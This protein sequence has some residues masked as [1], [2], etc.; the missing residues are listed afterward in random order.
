[1]PGS[2]AGMARGG[3]NSEL[4]ARLA[5]LAK[6]AVRS[7]PPAKQAAILDAAPS[8][9]GSLLRD[10]NR[11]LV[12][13]R[14][15]HGAVAGVDALRDA[16]A[17][18]LHVSVRYQTV[19]VAV[20][21]SDL[22][23]V[24]AVPRV[25]GVTENLAPIVSAACPAGDVVSEGDLQ[26]K[27]ADARSTYGV[28]GSGVT[29][30][31]LSD[32]FA[33][34]TTP[35]SIADNVASGD[36]PGAANPCGHTTPVDTTGDTYGGSDA[37]DEGRAMAQVVHDLAPGAE[38]AFA[39]AFVSVSSFADNIRAL[40][41]AG[42]QVIV[43]DIIYLD[44]PFFQEGPVAVAVNDAT[45]DGAAYFSAAG[46]NNL[47]VGGNNISSWETPQFRGG[48]SNICPPSLVAT[49]SFVSDCLDFDPSHGTDGDFS[50]VVSNGA[51][52]T[53]DLQWAQPWNG[54]TSD[55][56][57]YLLDS[58]GSVVAASASDN[59]GLT[60][61]P[62]EIFSWDNTSGTS[63]TVSLAID[64]CFGICN[65]NADVS[66]PRVKFALLQNG[67]GVTSTEYP[68]SLGGDIVGPT[69]FG[70]SGAPNAM[71]VGAIR[72]NTS[73]APESFSSRGPVVHYFGA[74]SGTTPAPPLSA[75]QVISKPDLVATDCNVT[76]GFFGDFPPFRFCG[77]SAAAPHAA[78]IAALEIDAATSTLSPATVKEALRDTAD[79]VGGSDACA[80][81]AGIVNALDAVGEIVSPGVGPSSAF[82]LPPPSPPIPE[83]PAPVQASTAVPTAKPQTFIALHPARTIFI[84]KRGKRLVFRFRSDPA[85]AQFLCKFDQA[86]FRLCPKKVTRWFGLGRHVV[87]VKAR[88]A[89]G[90][91]DP[92]PAVFRFRIVSVRLRSRHHRS[93]P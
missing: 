74:V 18:I 9:P 63:Q 86:P 55:L 23:D 26:L 52:L 59:V 64:R 83:P 15:D 67:S 71:S 17:K 36:L 93:H 69:V 16:G 14:F 80:V 68:Q 75:P 8:G 27:A 13:V 33:K 46:N 57:A 84:R 77:T 60:G 20:A 43:D 12:D 24:A 3:A 35:T 90:S 85:G 40:A 21:P 7:A 41:S 30:G 37:S 82:C 73:S 44:E 53:V 47:I 51:T 39:S 56:D 78:A 19:T 87:Q 88:D 11:V 6:P 65:P 38:L 4:S 81:G 25:D 29:V 92:T 31:I 76:N 79:P 1:M 91:V 42:A 48:S 10:G 89:E 5:E 61:K 32:S 34:T 62:V 72:F 2:A 45:A 49:F 70:H 28:D 66:S 50:I 54:V 22:H 58:S